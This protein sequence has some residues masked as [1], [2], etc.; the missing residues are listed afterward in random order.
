MS[1]LTVTSRPPPTLFH[2]LPE[3]IF[4]PSRPQ[5]NLPATNYLSQPSIPYLWKTPWSMGCSFLRQSRCY[6]LLTAINP[7]ITFNGDIWFKTRDFSRRSISYGSLVLKIIMYCFQDHIHNY[8]L[9]KYLFSFYKYYISLWLSFFLLKNQLH[10][11]FYLKKMIN[12]LPQSNK[13]WKI[14]I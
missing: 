4:V 13:I 9:M 3:I 2:S 7:S 11:P 12:C 5:I 14:C 6:Y 1:P 10:E 8:L